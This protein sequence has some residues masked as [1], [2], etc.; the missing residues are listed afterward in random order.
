[1]YGNYLFNNQAQVNDLQQMRE[2]IDKQLQMLNHNQPVQTAP[3]TQ[4][5]QLAPNQQQNQNIKYAENIEE[6]KRELVFSDT[7]FINKDFTILWFKNA[8]GEVKP[9]EIRELVIKDEKDLRIEELENKLNELLKEREINEE[10]ISKCDVEPT[11]TKK[12]TNGK[13]N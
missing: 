7:L 8:S 6:V 3:I 13:S 12:S 5:F 2:R 9:F 1:M 4:N 10:S 11:S